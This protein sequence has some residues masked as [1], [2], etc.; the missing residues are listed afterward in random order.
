MYN[1]RYTNVEDLSDKQDINGA[2]N[3]CSPQVAVKPRPQVQKN[4]SSLYRVS[5]YMPHPPSFYDNVPVCYLENTKDEAK[6][7]DCDKDGDGVKK[8]SEYTTKL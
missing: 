3:T 5:K 6:V 2:T 1:F 4:N 7:L 8:K